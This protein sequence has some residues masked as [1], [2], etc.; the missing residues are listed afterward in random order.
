MKAIYILKDKE[1]KIHLGLKLHPFDSYKW[2]EYKKIRGVPTQDDAEYIKY[3]RDRDVIVSKKIQKH[4]QLLRKKLSDGEIT[5][6]EYYENITTSDDYSQVYPYN[7]LYSSGDDC[8]M[9]DDIDIL[10][11]K[12]RYW[13]ENTHQSVRCKITE[14]TKY[15]QKA[16]WPGYITDDHD[17]SY[18]PNP[19][20][21]QNETNK[22]AYRWKIEN[23]SGKHTSLN[24]F[25]SNDSECSVGD[26]SMFSGMEVN[27][28]GDSSGYP[29]NEY[30]ESPDSSLGDVTFDLIGMVTP[31]SKSV[32]R[33]GECVKIKGENL[34]ISNPSSSKPRCY[35][36]ILQ[37]NK[38]G[39]EVWT[40]SKTISDIDIVGHS[41]NEPNLSPSLN[42][43]S[44]N[45]FDS[46]I[47]IEICP[48]IQEYASWVWKLNGDIV[49]KTKYQKKNKRGS[50]LIVI[51]Y[52]HEHLTIILFKIQYY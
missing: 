49:M 12:H 27:S 36:Y 43:I 19:H 4:K 31:P 32:T 2:N 50:V 9:I 1:N 8:T 28:F 21:E 52:A 22:W 42:S 24:L 46:Y 40:L 45:Y 7:Y 48:T 34:Y 29:M 11:Y 33:F 38:Y 13:N 10:W 6:T 16:V 41:T 44:I 18:I 14:D 51:H 39:C 15:Y 3:M 30:T 37:T 5:K 17:G 35:A 26:I 25:E 47:E 20:H 23:V